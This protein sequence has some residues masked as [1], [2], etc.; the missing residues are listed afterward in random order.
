MVIFG[1]AGDLT[2]R[3]VVPA[4][5][6]LV[7]RG[8]LSDDFQLVGVDLAGKTTRDWQ[9]GLGKMMHEFATTGGGEFEIDHID[10]NDWKWLTDRMSYIQGDLTDPD[11]YQRLA[12]HLE[13]LKDSKGASGNHLFYLAVSERFFGAAVD[14]LGK[15]GLTRQTEKNWRRVII[16]KPFGHDLASA[17]AL[18]AEVLR[19]LNENQIYRID[20]FLGKETVQNIMTFR[21]ANGMFEPLWNRDHISHIQ[22]SAA[23]TIGVEQRGRFYEKTGALRDMVPNHMFQLLSMVAMEPP[24]SF[25]ADHIRDKKTEAF[26]AIHIQSLDEALQNS[27]RGQYEKGSVMGKSVAAYRDEPNVAPDSTT[28]TYVACKL[29]LDNWRWAGVPFYI[30]T[31]KYMAAHKTEIAICFKKAPHSMFRKTIVANMNANWLIIRIQPHEG[32]EIEFA[33]KRP[34]P[35]VNLSK[36]NMD[37]DYKSFFEMAPNTGYETL[38][39]DCMSGDATLFQRADNVEWAW[40]AIQPILDAWDKTPPTDL[41][42]YKSGSSVPKAADELLAREGFSWRELTQHAEHE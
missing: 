38:L 40:Q 12:A 1:A 9:D 6:N 37:F 19:T 18:N 23:E 4:L 8:R 28:E 21:F 30:R 29:M 17:K 32:I 25:D 27:V 11:A 5:Y 15:A 20:H 3:L 26:E 16:E 2:K 31:G 35:S 42:N 33:A 10:E 41:P 34:G 22:I 24:V 14:G 13:E 39:Y 7:T 36:V